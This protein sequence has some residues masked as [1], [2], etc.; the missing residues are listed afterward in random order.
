MWLT[1][2]LETVESSNEFEELCN[3]IEEE[4]QNHNGT[5]IDAYSKPLRV[6]KQTLTS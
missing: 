5:Y 6:N 2:S 1:L 3:E 4:W